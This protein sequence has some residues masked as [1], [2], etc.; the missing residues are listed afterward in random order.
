MNRIE[1]F[2]G[3]NRLLGLLG[4]AVLLLGRPAIAVD[5]PPTQGAVADKDGNSAERITRLIEQL[6]SDDFGTRE[7]AQSELAQAGLEAYDAL[8]AA[9]SHRDPEIALRAR[10]LVDSMRVRW[11]ADSDSAKV[12]AILKD[13]GSLQSD[14]QVSERGNRIDRL[15]GLEDGAGIVP[16]VRLARFETSDVLAKYAALKVLE[17]PP[18]EDDA[19]KAEL[20]RQIANLVGK[21]KRQS[22]AW[23]RLYGRTLVDPASTL[24]EWDEAAQAEHAVLNGKNPERTSPD[25]VRDF[26]RVQVKLL[27]RLD[28]ADEA[29]AV[30]RRTFSLL[31]KTPTSLQE[32]ADWLISLQAWPVALELLQQ[33]ETTVAE[34][35]KLLYRLACTYDKLG[36]AEQAELA[37]GK[38]LALKPDVPEE[39]LVIAH[40]LEDAPLLAKWA[41]GEYRQVLQTATPGSRH[42]FLARFKLAE[43]LHDRLRELPAAEIMAPVCE[44]FQKDDNAKGAETAKETW[45]RLLDLPPEAAVAR[46]NYFYA[47]HFHEQGDWPKEKEHLKAAVDAYSKDADVLIAMYRLPQADEAWKALAKEKIESVAGEFRREV[48]EDR[49]NMEAADEQSRS[50]GMRAFAIACNQY[51]WLVGNTSGDHQDAL[52]LSQ[53]SVEIARQLPEMKAHLAGYLDTLGRA[54]FGAGDVANAAKYQAMAVAL[55]PTS[56]QIRRQLEF[57]QR[58]ARDRGIKLPDPEPV[59]GLTT[60]SMKPQAAA[61]TARPQPADPF[62]PRPR[63]KPPEPF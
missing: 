57:F 38:A 48:D 11:F 40:E 1:K 37:A 42:D 35:P 26:Y 21:S 20:L 30:M 13:Y 5:M 10:Y 34:S 16:L 54:H 22:A 29:R 50:F 15:A 6:G 14:A 17:L 2:V 56:G 53:E 8:H 18:P 25:I 51:A 28:R 12:V 24:A 63:P 3:P 62:A 61:P 39:H 36:N 45:S 9:R 19:G 60:K 33:F 32:T 55:N 31:D 47:C 4:V 58:E 27:G 46:M 41:E 44:L 43:L 52:K 7:K 23:L 49:A 59:D